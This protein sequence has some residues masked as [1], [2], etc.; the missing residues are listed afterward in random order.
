MSRWSDLEASL[1]RS[2]CTCICGI[3]EAGRGPLAGPVIAAAVILPPGFA[4]RNIDDSKR[5]SAKVREELYD[6]I[7]ENA[8]D[9]AIAS[10]SPAKI[11][12]INILQATFSAMRNAYRQLRHTPDYVLVDGNQRIPNLT[13]SQKAIVKGDQT[14]L[15]IACASILAKVTRDRIMCEYHR[16]YPQY[17]FDRHKGYPTPQHRAMIEAHGAIDIHRRSF[18]LLP[19]QYELTLAGPSDN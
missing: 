16:Q 12:R 4:A 13:I 7:I 2:G 18:T 6:Y 5:L 17:G 14:V 8:R 15:A 9:Y 11:D 10:S 1:R 3:D 19:G